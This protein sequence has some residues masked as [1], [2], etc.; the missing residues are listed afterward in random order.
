MAA[1]L[2]IESPNQEALPQLEAMSVSKS[3]VIPKGKPSP[4]KKVWEKLIEQG[5][6]CFR[7]WDISISHTRMGRKNA[8]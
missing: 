6:T 7:L 8:E 3:F 2:E 5:E 4:R 1:R